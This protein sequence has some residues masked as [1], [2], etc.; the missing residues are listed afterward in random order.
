MK[1]APK[2]K[3]AKLLTREEVEEALETAGGLSGLDYMDTREEI[4][5]YLFGEKEE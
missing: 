4:L 3:N 1:K 2:K 5:N